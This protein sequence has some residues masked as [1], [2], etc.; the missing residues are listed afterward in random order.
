MEKGKYEEPIFE[1]IKYVTEDVLT[2]SNPDP[3]DPFNPEYE[4]PYLF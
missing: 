2:D 1:I 4:G 3:N